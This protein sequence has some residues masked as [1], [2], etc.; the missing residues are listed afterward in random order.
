MKKFVLVLLLQG[1]ALC[2]FAQAEPFVKSLRKLEFGTTIMEAGMLFKKDYSQFRMLEERPTYITD[3]TDPADSTKTY[4]VE[5]F[6]LIS[7]ERKQLIQLYYLDDHLY[8]KGAYWFYEKGDIEG[9]ETKYAK[10]INYFKSD[11]YFIKANH[12]LVPS[13]EIVGHTSKKTEFLIKKMS[14]DEGK[15]E[16]GYEALYTKAD[17]NKGFWVYIDGINT[18]DLDVNRDMEIPKIEAPKVVLDQVK[19]ALLSKDAD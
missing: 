11:P 4:R 13:E 6:Y 5:A 18:L 3:I 17:G 9:V 12:G 8:Q 15:G 1:F 16:C 7:V 14:K 10:C 19:N 2:T